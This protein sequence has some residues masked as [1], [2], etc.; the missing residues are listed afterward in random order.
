MRQ[1]LGE[2]SIFGSLGSVT[3]TMP[4]MAIKAI[5]NKS[6]ENAGRRDQVGGFIRP[7]IQMRDDGMIRIFFECRG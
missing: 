6:W 5:S 7:G 3:W 4:S 2:R 1:G